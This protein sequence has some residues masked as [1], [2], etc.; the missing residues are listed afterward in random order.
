MI[1]KHSFDIKYIM[2]FPIYIFLT[3]IFDVKYFKISFM[4]FM[5]F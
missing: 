4:N 3:P 1:K 5:V 2:T